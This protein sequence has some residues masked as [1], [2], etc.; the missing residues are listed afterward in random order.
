VHGADTKVSGVF[1]AREQVVDTGSGRTVDFGFTHAGGTEPLDFGSKPSGLAAAGADSFRRLA[2]AFG[3]TRLVTMNQVHGTDITVVRSTDRPPATCDALI[4]DRSG[5]ALCA[6]VADCVPVLLFDEA[7]G[8]VGAVHAGR[9]GVAAG[10]VSAAIG[11]MRRHGA[12]EITGVIGPHVCGGC[13]EVPA[14]MRTDV[15]AA[16]PSCFACTTWG[17]PSIDLGAGVRAQLDSNG[18]TIIERSACTVHTEGLHS[19]RRDGEKSGRMAAVVMWRERS[20][21]REPT[22]TRS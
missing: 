5:V 20:T 16:V 14:D 8:L 9:L 17:T 22:E 19:Y 15:A 13:Y 2:A 7:H 12:T 1:Y 18:C 3:V 21:T 11:V 4:T 10:V 6:R